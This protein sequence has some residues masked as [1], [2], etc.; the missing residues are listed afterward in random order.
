VGDELLMGAEEGGFAGLEIL[1]NPPIF[2][3][4]GALWSGRLP[5]HTHTYTYLSGHAAGSV[6]AVQA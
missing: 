4:P 1:E 5:Q 3:D 2:Q 6:P